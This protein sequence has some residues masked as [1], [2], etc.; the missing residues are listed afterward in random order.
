MRKAII[1]T[2]AIAL[3]FPYLLSVALADDQKTALAVE[4]VGEMNVSDNI[5]GTV[6]AGMEADLILTIIADM[7][8]AEPGEEIGSISIILPGGFTARDGAVTAVKKGDADVPNFQAVVDGNRI[9]V[10]LPTLIRLS[11]IITI[12]FT[13]DAPP[14]PIGART[15]MVSLLDFNQQPIIISIQSGNA[16][17]RSNN[18]SLVVRTVTAI[19]PDPPLSVKA[20]PDSSGENDIT[21][22]WD[23][24]EDLD[25]GGY[26]V[27]RS[28]VGD[29]AVDLF[30]VELGEAEPSPGPGAHGGA[31]T[32]AGDGGLQESVGGGAQEVL[33]VQ[34]RRR[35]ALALVAVAPHA[36]LGEAA[37]P[38]C[39]HS[40]HLAAAGESPVPRQLP[41]R[42]VTQV[43]DHVANLAPP[44]RRHPVRAE[45][46]HGPLPAAEQDRAGEEAV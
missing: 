20:E 4:S 7:S 29:D 8:Q 26:L 10:V 41:R 25:V 22:S 28:D 35:A 32:S 6:F 11:A 19:K 37:L 38:L 21:I 14:T 31:T 27:Y 24:S 18:D 40:L 2:F 45:G 1:I 5:N 17:G 44:Q 39:R 13:V 42:D 9:T 34:G 3:I 33:V 36:E 46:A 12:E 30:G 43:G 15:F 23:K 16:D